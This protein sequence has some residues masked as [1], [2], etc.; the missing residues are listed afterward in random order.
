MRRTYVQL[1]LGIFLLLNYL[2]SQAAISITDTGPNI[3][4]G[5]I[6]TNLPYFTATNDDPSSLN[7]AFTYSVA[8]TGGPAAV[9]FNGGGLTFN[10]DGTLSGSTCAANGNVTY[11]VTVT[12]TSTTPNQT[13][14]LQCWHWLMIKLTLITPLQQLV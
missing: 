2:T 9:D 13:A 12:D 6:Y 7:N 3:T 8:I 5:G 1:L 11:T 10:A 4:Q 14:T